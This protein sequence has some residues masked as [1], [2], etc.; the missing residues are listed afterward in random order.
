MVDRRSNVNKYKLDNVKPSKPDSRDRLASLP[1]SGS[2]PSKVDL[3]PWANEVEDQLHL[4]S[5]TANTGCSALELA[6]DR[7]GVAKD[8]SRL[9]LY[10][11]TRFLGGIKEDDGA[12][13]RDIGKALNKYGVCLEPTWDYITSMV[14]EKPDDAAQAEAVEYPVFA[15]E[16]IVGT[17]G[18]VNNQIKNALAQ[19]IPVMAGLAIYE[20]FYGLDGDW[21]THT[22]NTV[23]SDTNQI[24]GY[25]MG[26]IIGYDD[27]TERFLVENSWGPY[28]GDGGFYGV[29]YSYTNNVFDEW[30]ILKEIDVDYVAVGDDTDTPPVIVTPADDD[31]KSKVMIGI[32][33]AIAAIIAIVVISQG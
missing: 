22:W 20:S 13:P 6:Y 25:H 8:F 11:F 33:V 2:L 14:N 17:T 28:W 21:Q 19:G 32:A 26:L 27:E 7:A 29:P 15:Y 5:C 1:A 9:Y 31:K 18:F 3:K 12:Y 16:R 4:S 30:W 24:D 10:W 23:E